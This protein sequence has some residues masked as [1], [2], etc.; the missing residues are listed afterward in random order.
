VPEEQQVPVVPVEPTAP[1]P[2]AEPLDLTATANGILAAAATGD[3]ES[4]AK[5]LND[6]VVAARQ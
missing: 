2:V 1:Q 6:L 3:A 5:L 4:L